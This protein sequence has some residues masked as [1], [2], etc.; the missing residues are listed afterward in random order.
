M[1]T[2]QLISWA[3]FDKWVTPKHYR[4]WIYRG[5][6]DAS[7]LLE[8]SLHR[9]FNHASKIRESGQSNPRPIN[10]N[11]HEKIMLER[12]KSNAHLYLPH[13]PEPSDDLSWLALM[14]H[15]GAP[16][17]LLDFTFSP[18]VALFF[19]LESGSEDAS[20][21]CIDHKEMKR[22]DT[23]YFGPD[24][25]EVYSRFLKKDEHTDDFCM[26]AFE[27][28]FTNQRLMA[29]QGLLVATNT[30]S[31]THEEI[32]EDYTNVRASMTKFIIPKRLRYSGLRKLMQMNI[33]SSNLYPGLEGFCKGMTTQPVLGL[34]WQQ[35]LGEIG[36]NK[37]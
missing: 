37:N 16:T 23:S 18:Y 29:Q 28:R 10:R 33:T 11:E 25:D 36:K 19:A 2:I 15:H 13:L 22:D 30:L 35:R 8:S 20:L 9:S 24:T 21:Y 27:P 5:H 7:W 31:S 34:E 32:L 1:E 17:R 12:F 3:E 26:L 14:Q 6:S 4:K